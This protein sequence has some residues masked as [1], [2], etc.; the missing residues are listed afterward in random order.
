[1]GLVVR[2]DLRRLFIVE[3]DSALVNMRDGCCLN[4]IPFGWIMGGG[5]TGFREINALWSLTDMQKARR[6]RAIAIA[7]TQDDA[8]AKRLAFLTLALG[9]TLALL[10]V[11]F[12]F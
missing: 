8:A 11:P 10:A 12:Y 2:L 3:L 6:A 9:A 1:M 7:K 4:A 5:S